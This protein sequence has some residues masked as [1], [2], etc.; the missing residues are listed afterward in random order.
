MTFPSRAKTLQTI[1]REAKSVQ[2]GQESARRQ[3]VHPRSMF[4]FRNAPLEAPKLR[5][6]ASQASWEARLTLKIIG[7]TGVKRTFSSWRVHLLFALPRCPR[8]G[9]KAPQ[10]GREGCPEGPGSVWTAPEGAQ[11]AVQEES[12]PPKRAS[13]RAKSR[14]R[15]PQEASRRPL[16][17]SREASGAQMDAGAVPETLFGRFLDNFWTIFD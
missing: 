10:G 6:D 14:P 8:R 11:D 7:F 12:R 15:A 16:D 2:G 17:G 1:F 5:P 3:L 9:P 13:R 4:F